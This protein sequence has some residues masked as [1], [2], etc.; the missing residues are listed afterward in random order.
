[1]IAAAWAILLVVAPPLALSAPEDDASPMVRLL[2]IGAPSGAKLFRNDRIAVALRPGAA[3]VEVYGRSGLG[4]APR[5]LL[6]P[7]AV[8]GATPRI[9]GFEILEDDPSAVEISATFEMA[10]GAR[11]LAGFRLTAGEPFLEVRP[12]DGFESLSIACRA[13]HAVVPEFFGDDYVVSPAPGSASRIGLP[14]ENFVLLLAEGGDAL[15][16]ALWPSSRESADLV[17]AGEGPARAIARCEVERGP[18]ERFWFAVLEGEGIWREVEGEGGSRRLVYPLDRTRETPLSVICPIDVFRNT[19][20]VGPCQYILAQEGFDASVPPT[21]AAVT[22][23]IEKTFERKREKRSA[24]EIEERLA[25]MVHHLEAIEKRTGEY[26][27]SVRAARAQVE[28]VGAAEV[29][30]IAD[31]LIADLERPSEPAKDPRRAA[32]L[33]ARIPRLIGTEGAL[34]ACRRIGEEIRALGAAQDRALA[35]CRLAARRITQA[36]RMAGEYVLANERIA[37]LARR[38]SE[39]AEIHAVRPDG[40]RLR[41]AIAP[42]G[43]AVAAGR[44]RSVRPV[45]TDDGGRAVEVAFGALSLRIEL[46]AGCSFVKTLPGAGARALRLEVPCRF[47]VLPDFFADDI[48]I[49][50]RELPAGPAPLPSENFLLQLAGDGDGIVMA[51]SKERGEDIAVTVAGE[52]ADRSIRSAEIAYGKDGAVWV[53]LLEGP[54][55]WSA[56]DVAGADAGETVP[57]DWSMPFPALWRVDFRRDDA[58]TDSWEMIRERSDGTFVKDNWFGSPNTLPANRRR[59]TTVLGWFEYPCWVDRAGRGH[60]APFAK[61]PVRFEGP[62]VVYPIDRVRETPLAALTVVDIVRDTLGV[63]PCEYILDVEGQRAAYKGRATCATRD[64]LNPIYAKGEQRKR[65]AEIERVLDEVMIFVRHIRGRI[66]SYVAFGRA[67][68]AY[69][70]AERAKHPELAEPLRELETLARAID[71]AV[72]RR[73]EKIRAPEDA[74]KLVEEFRTTLLD[75]E[76][77]DAKAKCER[78]T[79]AIVGIGGNQDELVGECRLAVRILRQRAGL[80]LARDPRLADVAREIR[81]RTQEALRSPT[82]YEAPRH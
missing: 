45:E 36:R 42:L 20:G 80:A 57:L 72:A 16:M 19:L 54:D 3:G 69:L 73:K 26:A 74:A 40:A 14:A 38:G 2:D 79:A 50:A 31:G 4:S 59:W 82:T 22:E 15:A 37:V 55:I 7:A 52:G 44:I 51:V 8:D 24:A 68:Q 11:I 53:G 23:W 5:G 75:Y 6:A 61:K 67:M 76:G 62:V 81:R 46:D 21:A 18:A 35:L 27:A 66:E 63:G 25:A 29:R 56:G 41:A 13:R 60:L 49:D 70:A 71:A 30:A 47:A 64:F 9:A 1:M 28:G 17:I 58:I 43:D 12:G 48:V 65:R 78:I 39:G 10:G 77:S 34:E 32:D 33:A